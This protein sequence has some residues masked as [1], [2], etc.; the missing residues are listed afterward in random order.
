MIKQVDNGVYR[1]PQPLIGGA[2]VELR[3]KVR[4]ALD[5]ETG[6]HILLDGSPLAEQLESDNY[7]IR[8]WCHPLGEFLPPSQDELNAAITLIQSTKPIYVHCKAGVDRTGMV[9]A[10]YRIIIQKWTK[11]AAVAEM[12]AMGMHWWYYWWAWFL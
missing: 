10:H 5:L 7:G 12:K 8:T 9:I 4:N 11:E 3:G 2:W 6:S 1:G